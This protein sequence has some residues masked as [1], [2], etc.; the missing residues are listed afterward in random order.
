MKVLRASFFI[1]LLLSI[2]WFLIIIYL[3][4][5]YSPSSSDIPKFPFIDKIIHF[6]LFFIQ[7]FLISKSLIS[8][9]K[10]LINKYKFSI[11][12][13]L[14]LFAIII[15]YQ[16][17]FISFRTYDIYDMSANVIGILTGVFYVILLDDK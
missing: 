16:Q 14:I 6:F 2:L 12:S 4:L 17:Y 3:M 15:E 10:N 11:L 9:Q 7:S 1:Y 8:Y 5:F 13:I